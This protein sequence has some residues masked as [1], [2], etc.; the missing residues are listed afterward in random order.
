MIVGNVEKLKSKIKLVSALL[1]TIGY[2]SPF[3]LVS[4]S[5]RLIAEKQAEVGK[6]WPYLLRYQWPLKQRSP[7][8]KTASSARVD[9]P[10]PNKLTTCKSR[11]VWTGCEGGEPKAVAQIVKQWIATILLIKSTPIT[12]NNNLRR[13]F[14]VFLCARPSTGLAQRQ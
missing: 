4:H 5:Y 7:R 1:I 11:L 13:A 3:Y 14:V 9:N 8:V 6:G 12:R 10:R 2:F